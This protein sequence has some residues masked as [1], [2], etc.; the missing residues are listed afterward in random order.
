MF[1]AIHKSTG[2]LV[3]SYKIAEGLAWQ[4]KSKDEFIAPTSAINNWDELNAK[5]IREVKVSFVNTF[6]RYEGTDKK[7]KVMA[8]F[9]IET[10]GAIG[11]T[12]VNE[13][14]EHKL[15]K[16][17]I[18]NNWQQLILYNHENICLK[19]IPIEDIKIE[20]G[21]GQK[22]ADVLI[23]FKEFHKVLG[24][25]IAIE[26]QISPQNACETLIRSYDRAAYGYSICW[27]WSNELKQFN[28]LIKVIPYSIALEDYAKELIKMQ[29]SRFAE[30]GHKIEIMGMEIFKKIGD[31][32]GRYEE[33]N[34]SFEEQVRSQILH[35]QQ[36]LNRITQIK[37]E[38][39]ESY[40]NKITLDLSKVI[41]KEIDTID[42]NKL[43]EDIIKE[44]TIQVIDKDK[45]P[46]AH[47][48]SKDTH[49]YLDCYICFDCKKR[50]M[51]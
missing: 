40:K 9:R 18:Y 47:C 11:D 7:Q 21:I 38:E 46:C 28:N 4:G 29:D 23:T 44:K 50:T 35:N 51:K 14:E 17:Y 24:N 39:I 37:E 1:E 27:I 20:R 6:D 30:I 19:D 31:L 49:E 10:E 48:K 41:R 45:M 32:L 15:A 2:I 43:I 42:L 3:S 26:I 16:D 36:I 33:A 34:T 5:G 22:R 8:H 13:S 12:W 25:G